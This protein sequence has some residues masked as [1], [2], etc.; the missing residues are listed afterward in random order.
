MEFLHFPCG[1]LRQKV[2]AS[3]LSWPPSKGTGSQTLNSL[4]LRRTFALLIQR[5]SKPF[6]N[7]QASQELQLLERLKLGVVLSSGVEP[8]AAAALRVRHAAGALLGRRLR[9][10]RS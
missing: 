4:R 8:E 10:P 9:R 5:K 1:L 7:R 3:G 6:W 2:K